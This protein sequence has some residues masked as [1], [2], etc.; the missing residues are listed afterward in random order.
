MKNSTINLLKFYISVFFVHD[1]YLS[2]T[3]VEL[4]FMKPGNNG[5][6][7]II[8]EQNSFF[9]AVASVNTFEFLEQLF[10][11]QTVDVPVI[12][13][14]VANASA[15]SIAV[16]LN[17]STPIETGNGAD[18]IKGIG[19]AESI[20]T[21]IA[22][23]KAE[24][25]IA[26]I[27]NS[28]VDV[29]AAAIAFAEAIA[30]AGAVGIN[31]SST[32]STGNGDDLVVGEATA[33]GIA[34]ALV[35]ASANILPFNDAS[36]TVTSNTFI[37]TLAI[38]EI[39]ALAIGIRGGEYNLGNG[40]DIIRASATGAGINIGVQD[41]VIYGG[42][43]N[44]TFDLQSGTGEVIGGKG[45]DLLILEGSITDYNFSGLDLNLGVN[46]QNS[47]NSTDLFVSGVEEFKFVA[48]S[49]I[50]Y[51]YADLVFS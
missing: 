15:S 12:A 30:N 28:N 40:D 21:A 23:A 19:K 48:D 32:I 45:D 16:G 33:I 5:S 51:E 9:E 31:N 6:D 49:G 41:V 3:V 14:A 24:A 29:S 42:K 17:N 7:V 50:T 18:V 4:S 36:S 2:N 43:G 39:N 26:A 20:A 34:E 10:D 37:E 11:N 35:E 8:Q 38:T 1:I 47:N 25:I 44:D 22:S 46:I 13:T 27:N